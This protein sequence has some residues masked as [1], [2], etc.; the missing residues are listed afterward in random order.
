MVLD[1]QDPRLQ[2]VPSLLLGMAEGAPDQ[3]ALLQLPDMRPL[4]GGSSAAAREV[5]E[6]EQRAAL[7]ELDD[8]VDRFRRHVCTLLCTLRTGSEAD[9]RRMRMQAAR[10]AAQAMV[11]QHCDAS[12]HPQLCAWRGVCHPD[13]CGQVCTGCH[14]IRLIIKTCTAF[15]WSPCVCYVSVIRP[16]LF[17]CFWLPAV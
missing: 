14:V 10:G 7:S 2:P 4:L 9:R 11:A 15:S 17:L 16:L 6:R 5:A 13:D 12:L 3:A 1:L 8:M